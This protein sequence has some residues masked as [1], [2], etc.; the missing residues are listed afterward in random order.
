MIADEKTGWVIWFVGLPG[1]GKSTY[2]QAIYRSLLGRG[3]DIMYLS[4]DERRRTYFPKPEYTAQE[5]EQAY[6]MF[7]E[8]AA[9]LAGQGTNL[10]MDA[11]GHQLWM[12]QYARG[13]IPRF[14][15][16]YVRCPLDVAIKREEQRPEGQVMS[17]LYHK[18]L[19][20]KEK[21]KTFEGLGEMVGVDVPFEE[22]PNAECIIESDRMSIEEGRDR[23]IEFLKRWD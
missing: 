12:R 5:R 20:R 3:I 11:T 17:S 10:I 1:S 2:S 18:A 23:V 8:E 21:G 15:E 16:I 22:N 7:A 6:R 14:A 13:L 19:E 9:K 4:M